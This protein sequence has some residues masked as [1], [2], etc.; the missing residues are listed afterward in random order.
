[1]IGADALHYGSA[2]LASVVLPPCN[3]ITDGAKA[4]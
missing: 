2:F 1:M 3:P 4:H